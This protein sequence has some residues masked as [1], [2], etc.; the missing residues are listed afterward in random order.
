MRKYLVK[1]KCPF[2]AEAWRGVFPF[3]DFA[4]TFPRP[5][6]IKSVAIETFPVHATLW[7]EVR[8]PIS[9]NDNYFKWAKGF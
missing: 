7:S 9:D 1:D 8:P 4:L 5:F 2:A 6:S 3:L